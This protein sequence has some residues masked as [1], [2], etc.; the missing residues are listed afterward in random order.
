MTIHPPITS[1]ELATLVR[2]LSPSRANAPRDEWVKIGMAIKSANSG[3]T[4]F[5]LFDEFSRQSPKYKASAVRSTWRSI[6]PDG[7]YTVG[8]LIHWANEDDPNGKRAQQTTTKRAYAGLA[9]YAAAHH[10]P[11]EAF[12]VAGWSLKPE[13]H[14]CS[15]LERE[16][17][18]LC[19]T[20]ATGKR[21][22]YT[23]G[24][25]PAYTSSPGYKLC[26]YRLAEAAELAKL[27]SSPLII[28]NGEAS[29]AVGQYHG[30]GACAVTSGEKGSIA[31]HLLDEL[32]AAWTG[33]IIIA[34]DCDRDGRKYATQLAAQLREAGY[35]A[36]A[37]DLRGTFGYDFADFC[38]D[39]N[40]STIAAL[41]SLPDVASS[42]LQEPAT[43]PVGSQ[44]PIDRAFIFKCL[45]EDEAGDAQLLAELYRGLLCYDY[46]AN[47][48]YSFQGHAWVPCDGLPRKLV[49]SKVAARYLEL[50]AQVQSESTSDESPRTVGSS[51]T[52]DR[53]ITR[54]KLLCATRRTSNVLTL[55]QE[56]LG[57]KGDEW[58]ADPWILAVTNGVLDLRTGQLRDGRPED[59]IRIVAPT[60]WTGLDTPAPR[61]E[62]FISEVLSN[63]PDR[64]AFLQRL[65]GFAL[66]GTTK[67]H[68][69]AVCVGER[70]RNGKR[71]LFEALQ[72][73]LGQYAGSISTDVLV[74][75]DRLRGAGSA[76]PHL[77]A[78]QGRRIAYASETGEH[79][80]L[81]SAQVKNITGGDPITARH[82]HQNLI[83]FQP[84]HT[85]FL[86]TNRKPEA[87]SDDDALWERVK[88]LE[89]KARFVDD[90]QS[91]DEHPR[92]P[93]LE[94]H[95]TME[96]S[97]I[98]AWLVR[99]GLD[100]L[101]GGLQTPASVKLARD[102]YRQEESIDPF[103]EE[104]C[105]LWD[106]GVTQV[107]DL[108]TA[109][110]E[111][112]ALHGLR[113]KS[114]TWLG[115]EFVKRFEKD[116]IKSGDKPG[117]I[118]YLGITLRERADWTVQTLSHVSTT[119]QDATNP[120]E[121]IRTPNTNDCEDNPEGFE[122]DPKSSMHFF[123]HEE[124]K[125]ESASN[126]SGF[127]EKTA[128][129]RTT[130]PPEGFATLDEDAI[131]WDHV[132]ALL[133]VGGIPALRHKCETEWHLPLW[134]VMA[135]ANERY[136][137]QE[138]G[139]IVRGV[140]Q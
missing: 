33:E 78:L 54:A 66:N 93:Q 44:A 84:S 59:Y 80:K 73:V 5:A 39:H 111:W 136:P 107:S 132:R 92:D 125:L 37:V 49:W 40:G 41:R 6:R 137:F 21:W 82:L 131:D 127:V 99:G 77:M 38:A 117:R 124:K 1:D 100:W 116:R 113:V 42:D 70:G 81:S 133:R 68:V 9:E 135:V 22:R 79:D 58:D 10:A 83:T 115:K 101:K 75:Q 45:N 62:R 17:P 110:R 87:P 63:E 48:W 104:C 20:T 120:S 13:L 32:Q 138:I 95:L 61:W 97:G 88:V 98:L 60:A 67:E 30:Y 94:E 118:V 129:F 14:Y 91:P 85:I 27:S 103:L 114:T 74:G 16:R 69:L 46:A 36:R 130:K 18:A 86:Q 15:Q 31:S 29:T 8:S 108:T 51:K 134:S 19:F 24:L 76:Q 112:C 11:V 53:L 122:A 71:V 26:W 12:Q 72:H 121:P 3:D 57:I 25:K 56:L 23:D 90:P 7:G 4:G 50:A 89:F 96:A 65:L 52:T 35:T 105:E 139:P 106:G 34:F 109:Y 128:E 28:C 126:P 2:R 64:V 123:P 119:L 102:K 55:A 43:D 140:S 47:M